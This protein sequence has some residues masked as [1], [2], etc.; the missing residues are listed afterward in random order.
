MG[1]S[2]WR[3]RG[4]IGRFR[5]G[6]KGMVA[7][8]SGDVHAIGFAAISPVGRWLAHVT[9]SSNLCLACGLCCDGMVF[10]NGVVT[11]Q[12]VSP[13]AV[14]AGLRL[15]PDGKSFI[16]PCKAFQSCRCTVYVDRPETCRTFR[17]KTLRALEQGKIGGGDALAII[18]QA[19]GQRDAIR[20][21]LQA[22]GEEWAGHSLEGMVAP[23]EARMKLADN[24]GQ[25][26]EI[27][28]IILKLLVLRKFVH[29]HFVYIASKA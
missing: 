21:A 23:L 18:A 15:N 2:C 22:I 20:R 26:R 8:T 16:L 28:E 1:H 14:A 4:T 19:A 10:S 12:G 13:V 29:E 3:C 6:G 25:K 5:A 24:V 7:I 11:Q 9:E 27:G 17:C